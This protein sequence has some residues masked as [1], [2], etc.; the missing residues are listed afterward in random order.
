MLVAA[1]YPTLFV[2]VIKRVRNL[3]SVLL[4]PKQAGAV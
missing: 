3:S 4:E 1:S 2:A